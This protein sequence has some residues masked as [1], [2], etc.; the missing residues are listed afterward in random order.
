[1][2]ILALDLGQSQ[3]VACEY[4]LLTAKTQFR[5]VATE[6]TALRKLLEANRPE[7]VVVEIGSVTG[8]V[9]DLVQVDFPTFGGRLVGVMR[10]WRTWLVLGS[11][12]LRVAGL[13]RKTS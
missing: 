5:R 8:W 12:G 6:P 11:E 4:E 7:R 3:T 10:L 2:K 13:G 9:S 1:M